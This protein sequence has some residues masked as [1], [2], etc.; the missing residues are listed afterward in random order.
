MSSEA[1]TLPLAEII[2]PTWQ[3]EGPYAGHQCAF[4]RTG[5]CNL[6]CSWCDQPETWDRTRFDLARTC[7][8]TP[9]SRILDQVFATGCD[10]VV[11]TGGEPMI[12][13]QKPAFEW[14]AHRLRVAGV[15]VHVETNGTIGPTP[16]LRRLISHWSVSPKLTTADPERRRIRPGPITLFTNLAKTDRACFK[17]VCATAADVAA[18]VGFAEQFGLDRSWC[19]VMPQATDAAAVVKVMRELA[20]PALAAG[21][22]LTPRLH[23]LLWDDEKG[24]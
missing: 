18:V 14:L 13:A 22:R 9:V 5:W 16:L 24:R 21:F 19:W 3:G 4:I 11:L 8:D 10:M 23:T 17:F 12:H 15:D 1:E 2:W 7:P 6:S 20:E